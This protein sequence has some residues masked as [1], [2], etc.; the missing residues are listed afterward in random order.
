MKLSNNTLGISEEITCSDVAQLTSEDYDTCKIDFVDGDAYVSII[1][2]GKFEGMAV[3]SGTVEKAEAIKTT[4][5]ELTS[6][7]NIRY[8]GSNPS[9]YVEFGN[10]NELWR[11]IGIF[12][13]IGLKI[14]G[15]K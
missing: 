2:K 3:L 4:G 5:L 10:I 15:K 13:V 1:G 12:N 11:I 14:R 9:N 6:D 7:G 8:T